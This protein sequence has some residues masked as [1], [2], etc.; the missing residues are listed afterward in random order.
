MSKNRHGTDGRGVDEMKHASNFSGAI[1]PSSPLLAVKLSPL[2]LLLS[3]V[4]WDGEE[5]TRI[6]ITNS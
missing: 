1:A 3:F 2:H 6:H 4:L 5:V